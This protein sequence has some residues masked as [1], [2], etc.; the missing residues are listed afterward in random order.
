ME[1]SESGAPIYN[2]KA[3]K[4]EF[5]PAIGDS[6]NID[7]ITAHI[8]QHVGKVDAV[9][10]EVI[11]DL[12]HIDIHIVKPTPERNY[13]S[14]VTSGMS[15]LAMSPPAE[16]LEYAY[17]ELC[18]C[19]PP[20]WPMGQEDWEN[21]TYYWPVRM[22]KFLAR[23]P[24]ACQTWLWSQHTVPN[25]NPPSP[26]AD[27]TGLCGVILLPP[28][29][30]PPEFY[31]LKIDEKK[32]IHFHAVVP[33]HADEME[34]KLKRG[35]DAL[36]DG[37]ERHRVSELLNPFRP[38]SLAPT[39]TFS[40]QCQIC[41]GD[42]SEEGCSVCDADEPERPL[43]DSQIIRDSFSNC[44]ADV[45]LR[46]FRYVRYQPGLRLIFIAG[47]FP[48]GITALVSLFGWWIATGIFGLMTLLWVVFMVWVSRRT[49]E[50]FKNAALTPGLVVSTDPLE[51]ISLANMSCGSDL[52]A[53]AVKRVSIDRLPGH[54]AEVGTTFP[55]VSGFQDGERSDRW[56]DFS[57]EP[58]SWGT[59]DLALIEAR[60]RKLGE[61]AF[62]KLQTVHRLGR[63]PDKPGI[64][65]LDAATPP[66][67][68]RS[69]LPPSLPSS[70]VPPPMPGGRRP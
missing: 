40:R 45:R 7:L 26:F 14:L 46:F 65:W 28:L 24:H 63:Y 62:R 3:R 9:F 66:P 42:R 64:F 34:L 49:G 61:A 29:R 35:S 1:T 48:A 53:Y 51:I 16:H 5:E 60:R 10:H 67:L 30:L 55:C 11:S 37:F 44:S 25:G 38:S 47:L 17:S 50:I 32:T 33:L 4:R 23:F 21:E 54:P 36:F 6:E 70:S 41:G 12:V 19:L 31:T 18:I 27:N 69:A 56:G 39:R 68:P 8:E 2:H 22:L 13:Y 15:D 57:P 59:G 52:E 58:L 43:I 20:E